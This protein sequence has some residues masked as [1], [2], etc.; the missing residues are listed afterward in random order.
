MSYNNGIPSNDAANLP[1]RYKNGLV[2]SR[3]LED[4][5][6][7]NAWLYYGDNFAGTG[8]VHWVQPVDSANQTFLRN[9]NGLK[10][11]ALQFV[12]MATPATPTI[13]H[14]GTAGVI[15]WTYKIVAKNGAGSTLSTTPASAGGSTTT[16]NATLTSAN[17]NIITWASVV[18][19]ASYDVY[20]TAVGTTPSTTGK[21]GTVAATI[22]TATGIQPTTYTLN[23]TALVGDGTTAPTVN[24]S[25]G[26][27][28]GSALATPVGGAATVVGT[29]GSTTITY[30]IVA[31]GSTGTTAA[32]ANITT[33]TA[34]ATLS[35]TNFVTVTWNPVPGAL[36]YDVYRTAAG[37]TP[38]TTGL[39]ANIASTL[40]T[41]SDTGAAGDSS[42][43]PT[44]NT[45]GGLVT[46]I[47]TNYIPSETGANNALVA[48]LLNATGAAVPLTQ[49]LRILI[50]LG[51]TLQ[52]G[53]NTLNFN[54]AGVK[55]IK[56]HFNIAN[57]IA[58]AYAAT[59]AI[60]LLYDG[61]QWCDMSQ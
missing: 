54:G 19:A 31:R 27:G 48:A 36:S 53:A 28:T 20:R 34:N 6:V 49:G 38:S 57:N 2:S 45:T 61:T 11:Y 22:A 46:A 18:G 56:S 58:T 42:T 52:A 23:D 21:I 33:T 9:P 26:M 39:I 41:Y 32:S 16:G 35:A 30:K 8:K 43:A 60:D 25:G 37:G 47:A 51:H 13:T 17:Y 14:A 1:F 7:P 59:G 10:A 44:V 4:D 40:V 12:A 3:F 55:N 15:T 29:A 5:S 24:T 50:Q